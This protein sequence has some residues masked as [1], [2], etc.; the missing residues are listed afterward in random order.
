MSAITLSDFSYIRDLVRR[1]SAISLEQDKSYLLELR[2]APLARDAGFA[3]L[4]EY[5]GELRQQPLNSPM[6]RQVVEALTTHETFFFRD[7]HP[8]ETLQTTVLPKLLKERAPRGINIW[9]AAC[10]SGQEPYSI[11]ILLRES[12]P[13]PEQRRV[14]IIASDI[15]Q[16][17]I[18]RARDGIFNQVEISRGLSPELLSKYFDK[19]RQ[20]QQ[21][22][23]RPEIRRMVE[24]EASNLIG[25]WPKLPDLDIVFMRNV[26]IYF[27]VEVK[28]MLLS[29]VRQL[30][31]PDGY[32]FL[33]SSETTLNLDPGFA[34]VT[35]GKTTC[36]QL[37]PS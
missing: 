27:D 31:K 35:L 23:I 32:L 30:L 8:F 15:S 7:G 19:D 3:S 28:K 1:H 34:P 9:C 13:G 36:Y 10:S 24:F 25:A 2:L 14:R 37:L 17:I 26:M 22:R 21:W 33:G 20:G 29:K 4:S 11:A 18:E 6:Y 5:I 12:F 16:A